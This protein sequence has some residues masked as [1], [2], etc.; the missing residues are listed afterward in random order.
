[1]LFPDTLDKSFISLVN[2]SKKFTEF[3]KEKI[4]IALSIMKDAH[5]NQFRDE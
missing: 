1:M 4:N 5:K 3:E 2:E